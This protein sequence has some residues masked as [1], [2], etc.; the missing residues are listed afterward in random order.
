MRQVQCYRE[1]CEHVIRFPG[2]VYE[3]LRRTGN[4]FYCPAGHAQRFT[5]EAHPLREKINQLEQRID[6][7]WTHRDKYRDRIR[8]QSEEKRDLRAQL[9]DL[10]EVVYG[11]PSMYECQ[12]CGH[13]HRF[14]SGIGE[15]HL[16]YAALSVPADSL[17]MEVPT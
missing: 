11:S 7:L 2:P 4:T 13:R 16:E 3:Q 17:E 5:D 9:R 12:E 14:D 6:R 8:Q 15:D 1:D 10:R